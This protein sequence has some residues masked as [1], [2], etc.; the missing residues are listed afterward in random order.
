MFTSLFVFTEIDSE[1]VTVFFGNLRR[2]DL[3]LAKW[4]NK[5]LWICDSL[6]F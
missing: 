4:I 2:V 3:T 6:E 5:Y 1:E